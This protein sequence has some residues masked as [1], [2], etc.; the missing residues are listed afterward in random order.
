MRPTCNSLP[1][2]VIEY[3]ILSEKPLWLENKK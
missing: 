2:K 1:N 3:D